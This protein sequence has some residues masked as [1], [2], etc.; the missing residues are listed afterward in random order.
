MGAEDIEAEPSKVKLFPLKHWSE[1]DA[2]SAVIP[3]V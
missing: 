2:I 1:I 3:H